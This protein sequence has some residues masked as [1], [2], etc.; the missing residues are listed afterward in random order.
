[1]WAPDRVHLSSEGHRLLAGRAA[2]SL[3]VPYFEVHG[4]AA[5]PPEQLG[6]LGWL[7][8][9][10]LPW[11]GRRIRRVSSGDGIAPK[12]PSPIP[13]GPEGPDGRR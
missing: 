8:R 10:A 3:G 9:H 1:M 6:T 11:L 13:L 5:E 12:L 4:M 2:H 7:Q